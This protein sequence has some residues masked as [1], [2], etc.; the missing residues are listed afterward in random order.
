MKKIEKKIRG[1]AKKQKY[2][3][4]HRMNLKEKNKTTKA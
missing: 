4:L 1:V 2:S 3:D